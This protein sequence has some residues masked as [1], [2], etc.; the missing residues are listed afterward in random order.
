MPFELHLPKDLVPWVHPKPWL[1]VRSATTPL[2]RLGAKE[3]RL[4]LHRIP[5]SRD[6]SQVLEHLASVQS[7]RAD[8]MD[9]AVSAY[10]RRPLRQ[11]LEE[12][13]TAY[14]DAQG[15]LHL[16]GRGVLVHVEDPPRRAEKPADAA[17]GVVSVRAVQLL[18]EEAQPISVSELAH[19]AELSAGQAHKVLTLLEQEGFV[20][21]TGRG[22]A[23]RRHLPDRTALLDWLAR[24]PAATRRDRRLDVTLYA[25]RPEDLWKLVHERLETAGVEHAL[26]GAAAAS[27]WGAGP[28]NVLTSTVR[29]SPDLALESVAQQLGAEVTDRGANLRLLRDTGRVGG[30]I[31]GLKEGIRV[32]PPVRIYLDALAERRG[33]DVAQHFREVALGY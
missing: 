6:A 33:E 19:R 11:A 8:S 4:A 17:L 32:A 26:T 22:P 29:I 28:T 27:L 9:V 16:V 7:G 25:R 12:R 24:Q 20:R 10:L 3:L 1:R 30:A 5:A 2:L 31:S 23:R 15:H 14:L 21:T 18:L 13:E